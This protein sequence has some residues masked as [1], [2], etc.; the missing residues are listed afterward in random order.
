MIFLENYYRAGQGWICRE[1]T[2][3]II[4]W[5]ALAH[6][7]KRLYGGVLKNSQLIS[8]YHF[9]KSLLILSQERGEAVNW[10]FG[11]PI[12]PN[13]SFHPWG[14]VPTPPPPPSSSMLMIFVWWGHLA[15]HCCLL[16]VSRS[17][18]RTTV[19]KKE[20]KHRHT[21]FRHYD[22]LGTLLKLLM[23]CCCCRFWGEQ[24]RGNHSQKIN[25]LE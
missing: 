25:I 6:G 17:F 24:L 3:V 2:C 23:R 18:R 9:H 21:L 19:G 5:N 12:C 11:I 7:V 22:E 1:A 15:G 13:S 16:I 4:S 20:E 8:L 10:H 14:Y